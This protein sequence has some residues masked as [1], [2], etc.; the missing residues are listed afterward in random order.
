MQ[1]QKYFKKIAILLATY[2]GEKYIAEQ[3]NSLINQ[4]IEDDID[5]FISDDGSNDKTILIIKKL[6]L[7]TKIKIKKLLF[8]NYKNPFKNY[9]NLALNVPSNYDYYFFCDQDDIWYKKKIEIS[10]KKIEQGID[11]FVC[12]NFI[13][14][15][16][17]N[18]YYKNL[19][20]NLFLFI[21]NN[22]IINGNMMCISNKLFKNFKKDI[23]I[24]NYNHDHLLIIYAYIFN[25][26]IFYSN[27]RLI[28]WR[29]HDNNFSVRRG[30]FETFLYRKNYFTNNLIKKN[31]NFIKNFF[32]SC[33]NKNFN[34]INL[35]LF[36]NFVK[37]KEFKLSF[38]YISK[39]LDL[40]LKKTSAFNTFIFYI[41]YF[42]RKI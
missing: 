16:K 25:F 21:L 29:H 42:M 40:K 30:I 31:N 32:S 20:D 8:T 2:N 12:N 1:S 38:F 13:F 18:I 39:F 24:I 37:Y 4:T 15:Q 27:K 23:K 26:K 14:T 9:L 41:L 10:I 28:F 22:N 33:K 36:K 35:F 19:R 11:L 34:K 7:G 17:K 6:C 5:L 3:I